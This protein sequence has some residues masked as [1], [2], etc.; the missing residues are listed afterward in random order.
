VFLG[1]DAV[2][3]INPALYRRLPY[4]SLRNFVPV[5]HAANI[6]LMLVVHPS[7]PVKSVK[8]LVAF[9]RQRP[10]ELNYASG[11]TGSPQH[12]PM[13][14]LK[15][16]THIDIVHVPYKG[17]GPAFNDVLG[18]QV[19]MMFAG[20]SNA[21]P[22]HAAGRL[23]I[24]AIGGQRSPALPGVPTVAQAGVPGFYYAAWTA[25]LVPAGTPREVVARL[26]GDIARVLSLPDVR[27][28]LNALGFEL[29]G[30]TPAQLGTRL[31]ETDIARLGAVVRVAGIPVEH[32]SG[33]PCPGL[34]APRGASR[35][36]HNYAFTQ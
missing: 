26:H 6:P 20:M 23:R 8:E 4:D 2:L 15:A 14:M 19:P 10:G 34:L 16:A 35:I 27:E 30:S 13:E 12:L 17:L 7:L 36:C 24:L 32:K 31:K 28:R 29:I 3:A 22:H 11:G 9:A 5:T 18:G 21:V 1:N 25:Y 33:A